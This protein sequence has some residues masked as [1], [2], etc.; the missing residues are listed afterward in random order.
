MLCRCP[1]RS[2]D[3][4]P[5]VHAPGLLQSLGR[6][7][8]APP[9]CLQGQVAGTSTPKAVDQALGTMKAL[10]CCRMLGLVWL[11]RPPSRHWHSTHRLWAPLSLADF[12]AINRCERPLPENFNF[13]GDV[14]DQ[15]S[16]KEKV[17]GGGLPSG[18]GCPFFCVLVLGPTCH[19]SFSSF[20][21]LGLLCL[22]SKLPSALPGGDLWA[23]L[24]ASSVPVTVVTQGPTQLSLLPSCLRVFGASKPVI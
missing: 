18:A 13:A 4:Q 12:E 21:L 14:L 17:P 1:Q 11:T 22:F 9:I 8:Q 16:Q 20:I 23:S 10:S 15:W 2:G 5:Q 19:F 7:S 3:R 24:G 6:A